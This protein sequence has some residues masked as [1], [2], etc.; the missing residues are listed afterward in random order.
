MTDIWVCG[1]C[2]S[3]NEQRRGRCY[4]CGA[5]Q[6]VAATGEMATLR[7]EQAIASR[8][9][10]AY[11][12]AAALGLATSF[13]LL[14]LAVVNLAGIVQT[15]GLSSFLDQQLGVLEATGSID[16][17]AFVA[18][19][20]EMNRLGLAN[21]AVVLPAL[22]FFAAWLSR[23]VSNVPALGGGIPSTS[24]GRAF[25]NTLIPLVNLRTVPG[26]VQDVLYRLDP[27][28]GGVFMVGAAWFGLVGSWIVS[29]LAG[30]YL[31]LRLTFDLFNAA[32]LE[33]AVASFRT[34]LTLAVAIDVATGALIASGAVVL[35]AL[36]I[37]IE[38]RSRAR[39]AEV[40]AL[41]GV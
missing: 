8:T 13:F 2:H 38:R 40:R 28:G 23:V 9:V 41:A 16:E 1:T 10:V 33:E 4:K 26:M 18:R 27:R 3:I 30:W 32:S 22:L 34:L 11:R 14:G 36:M 7:Q 5:R 15:F 21:L 31:D 29:F 39:D 25:V 35:I 37:R 19:T 12:P 17:P 6:E 24:P 20:E